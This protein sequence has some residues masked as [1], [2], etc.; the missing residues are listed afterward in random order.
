MTRPN[1]LN[2][3]AF[4]RAAPFSR[5]TLGGTY[6]I[7]QAYL[8]PMGWQQLSR[9]RKL[10]QKFYGKP[11]RNDMTF[12]EIEVLARAY[13]CI[14]RSGGKHSLHIV[15]KDSGTVIPIP[16]HGKTVD[17]AYIK[18]LRDLFDSI[19]DISEG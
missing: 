5:L 17:E 12:E 8:K 4:R 1:Y 7:I 18:Q 9:L 6:D 15:H 19:G 10:Q 13:G 16:R 14:V 11:I 3:P 2:D